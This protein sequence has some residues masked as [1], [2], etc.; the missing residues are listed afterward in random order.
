MLIERD[1]PF[2]RIPTALES[3]Q[4]L[5][6]DGIRFAAE[7][8]DLS[9]LRL[10]NT[11]L[12]LAQHGAA[13]GEHNQDIVSA[14]VDAWSVVDS[15]YRLRVMLKH[16]PGLKQKGI[17]VQLYYRATTDVEV[18][19]HY[20]QH[21]NEKICD[22]VHTE[23]PVWGKLQ[24]LALLDRTKG[25]IRICTI[26]SGSFVL[27]Y[28]PLQNPIGKDFRA[29]VDH[30]ILTAGSGS[31]NIS[32]AMEYLETL[33]RGFEKELEANFQGQSYRASDM[34]FTV[35]AVPTDNV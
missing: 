2:R 19:R 34:L 4:A 30:I 27:G 5:F 35:D 7:A 1:S 21:L 10:V 24:W 12:R 25:I 9:Y 15:L 8:A 3:R 22:L 32:D 28:H 29:N 6:L 14:T 18:L 33:V 31:A 16:M 23:S 26:V 17:N 13:D 20:V 11:L